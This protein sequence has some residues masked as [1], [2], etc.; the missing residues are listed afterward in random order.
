VI[1]QPV[2]PAVAEQARLDLSLAAGMQERSNRPRLPLVAA[3]VLLAIATIYAISQA[4]ARQSA[5]A[6]LERTRASTNEVIALVNKIKT[7]QKTLAERGLDPNPRIAS[8]IETLARLSNA[9]L[10]GVVTDST[11]PLTSSSGTINKLYKARFESQ[12]PAALLQFLSAVFEDPQTNGVGLWSLEFTPGR[13][14]PTTG[15]IGWNLNVDFV[16]SERPAKR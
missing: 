16:R 8:E 12:P 2:P 14:D 11:A 1:D 7:L 13:P 15:E 6:K 10:T 9:Q 4:T 5:M 3:C